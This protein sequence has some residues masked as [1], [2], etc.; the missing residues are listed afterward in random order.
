MGGPNKTL[1]IMPHA[2]TPLAVVVLKVT[3]WVDEYQGVGH[4]GTDLQTR[5]KSLG[6]K[7][8]ASGIS[9]RICRRGTNH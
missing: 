3:V 6:T 5:Y 7:I 9:A 2:N 4:L 8:R 1:V